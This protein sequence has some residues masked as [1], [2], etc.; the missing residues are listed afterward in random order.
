MN[1][2]KRDHLIAL[3]RHPTPAMRERLHSLKASAANDHDRPDFVW[4]FLLQSFATM[5]NSRGWQ[6]L[7]GTPRN[8]ERVTYE[9]LLPLSPAARLEVLQATLR[10]AKIRMPD[11]KAAWLA[12]NI[13]CIE[14]IGGE[15]QARA[16]ALAAPGTQGKI[17]FMRQFAGI[18]DK[19]A[20]N[21]WMDVYDPDFR[22]TIAIDERIKR[23]SAALGVTFRTYAEH[24]R[25]YQDI[26]CDAGLDGWELDR[27]LYNF[28]DELLQRL[29]TT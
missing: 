13:T 1:A 8:Y 6:G 17:A 25:F 26:A 19:Y 23:I 27:L 16:A 2:D 24:E 15:E 7:I 22:T 10:A 18:G 28:T 5:G 14:A 3:L 9:H 21:I 4:H 12:H 20:R 29:D 11:K